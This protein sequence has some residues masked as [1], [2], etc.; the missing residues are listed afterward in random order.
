MLSTSLFFRADGKE[1]QFE[2][3]VVVDLD[4][5]RGGEDPGRERRGGWEE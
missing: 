1:R 4:G 2:V 3:I 5:D